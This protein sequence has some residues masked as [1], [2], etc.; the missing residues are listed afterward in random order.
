[1]VLPDQT[2][3]VIPKTRMV[4]NCRARAGGQPSINLIQCQDEKI[5]YS[6]LKSY[7]HSAW[8]DSGLSAESI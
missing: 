4:N 5:I 8:R 2:G 7:R 3:W 1:I 6:M